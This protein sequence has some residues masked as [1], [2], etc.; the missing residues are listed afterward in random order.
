MNTTHPY[1]LVIG[2]DRSDR[3]ADL[4]LIDTRT[5]QRRAQTID[6][7]PEALWEWLL[8]LRQ[9]Y[10]QARVALCLEQPAV[11]LVA[12]L[13]AYA[14]ITLYP[15]NPITLQ[16]YREAFVTSRAKDDAKD[17]QYLAELLLTHHQKLKLWAPEDSQTRALQQR[18]V[19]RRAVIDERTGLTNRLQG[20]LKQYFPQALVL[21]GEDLWRPLAT[22]FLLKWPS[23]QAVHKARTATLKQFY[24]LHGSRSAKLL[25]QRLALVQKAVPVTDETALIES[26]VLRVQ[27]ICRQLQRVQQTLGLYDQQIA[28]TY[29]QHPD[30]PIWA[31]FPGAGPVLGPRLLCSLGSQRERYPKPTNLQHYTGVAPVTKQS[32][33]KCHIHRRYLC[34]KFHRQSFHEYAKESVLWSRWAAAYYL[35]QRTKGAHHHTAVRALAFKWQRIIWR[36]WQDRQPYQEQ[37]YEAALRK[38]NSPLVGLLDKIQLGKSP[39]KSPANKN[40]KPLAGLPQR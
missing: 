26:F 10:P 22:H 15:I 21:C 31:S 7:S 8:E 20:L 24:Y 4:Y 28:Q 11:H 17:A 32:G 33:G 35:Q 6:T 27:L 19:H 36:C 40:E 30:H 3:K 13:E 12:F 2:L 29:R 14:W 38:A 9:D 23:L 5:G 18:V 16:K 34:P 39:F 1:D 25:D 37:I